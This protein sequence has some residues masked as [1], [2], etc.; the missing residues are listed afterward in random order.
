MPQKPRLHVTD[1]AI[2]R[3]L[4]RVG[5][6]D[7]EGLRAQ[8]AA[9]LQAASD[10]GAHSVRVDDHIFA[11][12]RDAIGPAVVTVLEKRPVNESHAPKSWLERGR[13]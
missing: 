3:Y 2:V 8:I 4:E 12:D 13:G 9:R 10:A 6:F 11:L 5:G 1:H 7:I